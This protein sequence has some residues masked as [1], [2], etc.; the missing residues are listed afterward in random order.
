M[1]RAALVVLVGVYL[2]GR[3]AVASPRFEP[4]PYVTERH[5]WSSRVMC[6][7]PKTCAGKAKFLR[8]TVAF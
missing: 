6:Y 8:V 1:T 2:A 3:A 7:R 4:E 5:G